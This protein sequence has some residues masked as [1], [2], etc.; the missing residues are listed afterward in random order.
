[1][2]GNVENSGCGPGTSLLD[3]LAIEDEGEK[4]LAVIFQEGL[5]LYN[6]L[7][8]IDEP[9]NSCNVQVIQY[10][11]IYSLCPFHNKARRLVIP[12]LSSDASKFFF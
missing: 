6:N 12:I 1:M 8:K 10:D 9:T 2:A 4:T 5:S 3:G 11:T 7:G